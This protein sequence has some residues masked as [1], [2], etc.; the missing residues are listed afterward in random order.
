MF[1]LIVRSVFAEPSRTVYDDAADEEAE[2]ARLAAET[3]AEVEAVAEEAEAARLLSEAEAAKPTA[4]P[5]AK[6]GAKPKLKVPLTPEQQD[7]VNSLVAEERRKAKAVADKAITQLETERN[8]AGT[9]QAEKDALEIRIEDL[10]ASQ[11]T[12]AE[13][14]KKEDKKRETKWQTEI[15]NRD[16]EIEKWK[17]L[18][19]GSTVKR[20]ITDAAVEHNAHNPRHIVKELASDTRLI[21]ELD[22]EGKPTGELV[23][24]VRMQTVKDGKPVTLDMT[25]TEAVKLMSEQEEHAPLFNSGAAGG[26]GSR[27]NN[28]RGGGRNSDE[29]PTDPGEYQEWRK[30]NRA[31]TGAPLR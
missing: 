22:E 29:P 6:P 15:T 13:L 31:K 3:E 4:R 20:A 5:P 7:F 16:K 21:E 23:P 10:K 19:T 14:A 9:T 28:P 27:P 17:G 24:R 1:D 18:Y 12:A 26:L 8:R 25:V 11:L 2:A 30:K